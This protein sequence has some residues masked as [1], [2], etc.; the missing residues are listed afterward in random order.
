MRLLQRVVNNNIIKFRHM[1]HLVARGGQP[2]GDD[3]RAVWYHGRVKRRS[4]SA[5]DG[6]MMKTPIAAGN[7][8][9]TCCAP[10]QS[11]S[12]STSRPAAI[13]DSIHSREVP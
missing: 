1:P 5:I 8:F 6:G 11:I 9:L 7:N 13:S 4:S 12:S 2:A 3:V 10:C